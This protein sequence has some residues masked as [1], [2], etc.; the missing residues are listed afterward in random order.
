[1]KIVIVLAAAL[2]LQVSQSCGSS[3]PAPLKAVTSLP[4]AT[5]DKPYTA[6]LVI[7]GTAPY[8]VT[9]STMTFNGAPIS[10]S[11]SVGLGLAQQGGGNKPM[12]VGQSVTTTGYL[13][14][15]IPCTLLADYSHPPNMLPYVA[16]NVGSSKL[17]IRN[18]Y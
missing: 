17:I 18:K 11:T 12:V 6:Q 9:T 1:M 13:V 3:G 16:A 2:F 15:T 4:D 8:Q 10:D 7:G 5:C 14:G